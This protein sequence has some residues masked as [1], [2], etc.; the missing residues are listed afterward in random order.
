MVIDEGYR[1]NKRFRERKKISE[2]YKS[3]LKV[4][5]PQ[6]TKTKKVMIIQGPLTLLMATKGVVNICYF[7][8]WSS[9]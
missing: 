6:N 1:L 7:D 4:W 2:N 8:Q 5:P 9:A 3:E